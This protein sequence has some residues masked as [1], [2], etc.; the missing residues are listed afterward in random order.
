MQAVLEQNKLAE[1]LGSENQVQAF[2]KKI[3]FLGSL[4]GCWHKSLSR[5]FTIGKDS[6]CAC[7]NCGARKP[8]DPQALKI[9]GSF[10][11]PPSISLNKN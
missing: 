5:P 6:Y 7:L 8:F 11:Y 10:H 9:Y 2:G 1:S 4:F 3:G